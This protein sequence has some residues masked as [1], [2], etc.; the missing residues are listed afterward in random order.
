MRRNVK[1]TCHNFPIFPEF[2]GASYAERYNLLCKRLIQEKLYSSAVLL[3]SSRSAGKTGD[4]VDLVGL[5]SI[6]LSLPGLRRDWRW[7]LR[8]GRLVC[9]GRDK[10]D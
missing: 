2:R 4:Y 6:R 1:E 7:R 3:L 8:G 10:N 9:L 5:M